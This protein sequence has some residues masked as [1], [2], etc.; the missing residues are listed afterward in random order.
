MSASTPPKT[1]E[2]RNPR[3]VV[4]SGVRA[5]D[6]VSLPTTDG[7]GFVRTKAPA[8]GIYIETSDSAIFVAETDVEA[9]L[10]KMRKR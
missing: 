10:E 6:V 8:D 1:A 3:K 4:V 9:A 2:H 7:S 5:G